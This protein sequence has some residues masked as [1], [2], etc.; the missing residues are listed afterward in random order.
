M[1]RLEDRTALITGGSA[2]IGRAAALLFAQQGA[3]VVIAARN[4][5]HSQ[6]VVERIQA[7]GGVARFVP[8]DVRRPDDC[9][10]AVGATLDA[11]GQIDILFNNAGIVPVG[12]ALETTLETW[13]DVLATNVSGTFYMSRAALPHMIARGKGV[14]INCGSDNSLVGSQD[15]AAYCATKGAVA[16][17]TKA[18]ALDHGRQGIRINAICPGDT[19]VERWN[20]KVKPGQ[21]LDEYLD[22]LG[23]GFALGRVSSADELAHAILFL[24]SDDSSYM[25]GAL[26]VV[27]GGNSAGG[28]A[29]NFR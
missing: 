16:L 27:D 12:T 22:D 24:A 11:Y 2:G 5:E 21:T 26:L 10:R 20:A 6:Q 25:T 14:I 13:A 23:E 19:Y 9:E 4:A 18:M 15:S 3:Q 28:T 8:C 7:A 17:L 1:G 29:V